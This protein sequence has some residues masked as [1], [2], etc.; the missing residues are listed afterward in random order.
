MNAAPEGVV[1]A[2][3]KIGSF[4]IYFAFG[5]AGV[6]LFNYATGRE[7]LLQM[8]PAVAIFTLCVY[9]VVAALVSRV[10]DRIFK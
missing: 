7:T 4:L 9:G 6:Q 1:R 10:F 3:K 2:F 5:V 8:A